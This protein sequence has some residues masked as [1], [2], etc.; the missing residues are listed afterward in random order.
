MKPKLAI[1]IN[2]TYNCNFSCQFCYLKGLNKETFLDLNILKNQLKDLSLNYNIQYIDIYGGEIFLLDDQYLKKLIHIIKQYVKKIYIVT[3]LSIEK[4]WIFSSKEI[5]ISASWDY[6]FRNFDILNNL[7]EFSKKY[8]RKFTLILT[9]PNLVNYKKEIV[10]I[11]NNLD[12]N[13]SINLKSY[14]KTKNTTLNLNFENFQKFALYLYSNL[15]KDIPIILD[16][17]KQEYKH[18]FISPQNKIQQIH[19]FNNEQFFSSN[20]QQKQF[21]ECFICKFYNNCLKQHEFIKTQYDCC[22]H[23]KLLEKLQKLRFRDTWQNRRKLYYLTHN[24]ID[25]NLKYQYN[26]NIIG[27]T[28]DFF[29]NG[30]KLIYPAKSYYV[31]IIY[32]FLLQEYFGENFYQMLNNKNLLNNDD[33]YFKSYSEDKLTY[34][35]IISQV[36]PLDLNKIKDTSNYFFKEFLITK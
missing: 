24:I 21:S 20:L 16:I 26:Q 36:F 3:N 33:K 35:K 7:K 23:K 18:I 30:S 32:A 4:D 5:D 31:A 9:H 25:T 10:D 17:N 6:K 8:D 12:V 29:K 28:I 1:S 22:G 2:P 15:K 27:N 13:F 34:D 14:Y 11:L 19:Y